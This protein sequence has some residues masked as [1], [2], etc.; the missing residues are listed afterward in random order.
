MPL[1]RIE[2]R[3]RVLIP[4][5]LV[6][7]LAAGALL[8]GAIAPAPPPHIAGES[9]L[10][11]LTIRSDT[12]NLTTIYSLN[13]TVANNLWLGNAT[14][15]GIYRSAADVLK[16]DDA[17]V[18]M[19]GIGIGIN[20]SV[21]LHIQT[22]TTTSANAQLIMAPS[23]AAGSTTF[24]G[25]GTALTNYNSGFIGFRNAGTDST[26][27]ALTLGL[28]GVDNA[29]NVMGNGNVGVG[30]ISG[31]DSKLTLASST[32]ASGGIGFGSDTNLYRSEANTLRTDDALQAIGGFYTT[33]TVGY[34]ALQPGAS[35]SFARAKISGEDHPRFIALASGELQWGP[36]TGTVD[37]SLYRSA[38][39]T[40]KTDDEF[41]VGGYLRLDSG[42]STI[43]LGDGG[44][45]SYDTN[46]YRS[47]ANVLKTDDSLDVVGSM[48][49]ALDN[50]GKLYFGSATDTNLYRVATSNLATDSKFSIY[51]GSP[52]DAA[53]W[54]VAGSNLRFSASTDGKMEWHDSVGT[55][56]TNLYRSA[57]NTLKT[58]DAFHLAAG[59]LIWADSGSLGTCDSNQRG[60]QKMSFGGGGEADQVFICLKSSADTY[61]WKTVVTG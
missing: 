17:L 37:T 14:D 27:N 25:I 32:L 40:L 4:I 12:A 15:T 39:N 43:Y 18:A 34:D 35:N 16:T 7:L 8:P 1:P 2:P 41:R 51:R 11:D 56:D 5:G 58:D 31:V 24:L 26:G 36:G 19:G 61:S 60:F 9:Q 3:A 54:F 10:S 44:G 22:P 57:A 53:M 48:A 45:S 28:Y 29:L 50:T 52:T 6:F 55:A 23:L 33:S 30:V 59:T 49:I 42:S 47:A 13:T 20:P 46:I 21:R 38:A